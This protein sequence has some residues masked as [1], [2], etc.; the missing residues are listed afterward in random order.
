MLRRLTSSQPSLAALG[1]TRGYAAASAKTKNIKKKE[2]FQKTRSLGFKL[3]K[4]APTEKKKISGNAMVKPFAQT[5]HRAAKVSDVSEIPAIDAET[6][7][8]AEPVVLSYQGDVSKTCAI[9]SA[10]SPKRGFELLGERTT[11]LRKESRDVFKALDS[12]SRIIL[13]GP[14]NSGKRELLTH[15]MAYAKTNGWIVLPAPQLL[16]YI[17]GT[18]DYTLTESGRLDLLRRNCE[19]FQK[20]AAMNKEALEKTKLSK[21]YSFGQIKLTKD[22][23]IYDLAKKSVP[24]RFQAGDIFDAVIYELSLL[25]QKVLQPVYE[26]DILARP[27]EYRTPEYKQIQGRDLQL[28]QLI[29]SPP[30]NFVQIITA[31][32]GD[33]TA[34][35]LGKKQA[36]DFVYEPK[37][38]P[39]MVE[40][41]KTGHVIE[42]APVSALE[43]GL[44]LDYYESRGLT[45]KGRELLH[46]TSGGLLGE[47]WRHVRAY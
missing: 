40:L 24:A 26:V 10:F 25:K 45:L 31:H 29:K 19:F 7:K 16:Q 27:T 41:I 5:V 21:D 14:T 20:L 37:F 9:G 36:A 34:V 38:D 6:L 2:N 3:K 22:N 35:A 1:Q 12:Q 17:N 42:V 46:V 4:A 33:E 13:T 15:A 44:L 30:Q 32:E 28:A 11:L 43:S 18:S 23:S 8:S 47:L 39:S